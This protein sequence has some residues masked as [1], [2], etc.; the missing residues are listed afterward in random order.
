MPGMPRVG[1]TGRPCTKNTKGTLHHC[2]GFNGWVGEWSPGG[3]DNGKHG[4]PGL[5]FFYCKKHQMPCRQGCFKKAHMK[6]QDGCRSCE[7][8]WGREDKAEREARENQKA[9]E[10][11][12]E[13]EAFFNPG[14]GRKKDRK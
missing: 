11:S 9:I 14:K 8:N 6:N 13:E 4:P 7:F 10:K 1:D 5:A 2:P 3:C 12:K